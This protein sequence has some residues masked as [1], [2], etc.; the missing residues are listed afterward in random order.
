MLRE[1]EMQVA[2]NTREDN[3]LNA[4]RSMS[5]CPR[6]ER[7][8]PFDHKVIAWL[9]KIFLPTFVIT[10]SSG[11]TGE[12][13]ETRP[14]VQCKIKKPYPPTSS[15][16]ASDESE[17]GQ[18]QHNW[19]LVTRQVLAAY[20]NEGERA[21]SVFQGKRQGPAWHSKF[22]GQIE[23]L[24]NQTPS[25]IQVAQTAQGSS[26]EFPFGNPWRPIL[27]PGEASLQTGE[28]DYPQISLEQQNEH[29]INEYVA[30]D[31][32]EE[33]R[34]FGNRGAYYSTELNGPI[35]RMKYGSPLNHYG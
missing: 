7:N 23:H 20:R 17:A 33:L 13:Q 10:T 26:S 29:E 12:E 3:E 6:E 1:V 2:K 9:D 11:E 14:T 4:L 30:Y 8:M 35:R 27:Y 5:F 24:G 28:K 25:I 21:P 19:R 32:R 18:E 15:D 16:T 22:N 31:Y 34:Q